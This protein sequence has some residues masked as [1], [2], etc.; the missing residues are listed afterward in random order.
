MAISRVEMILIIQAEVDI[1]LAGKMSPR[2]E[3][4]AKAVA[5]TLKRHRA[6]AE[7]AKIAPRA[8]TPPKGA[9]EAALQ[10]VT[11]TLDAIARAGAAIGIAMVDLQV[12]R[13]RN[14]TSTSVKKHS[15]AVLRRQSVRLRKL[16][17]MTVRSLSR[18]ST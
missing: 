17:A 18:E 13:I 9:Q 3:D 2:Q 6:T 10:T 14:V 11:V 5:T 1:I 7:D 12:T 8:N 4:I 16:S 15:N